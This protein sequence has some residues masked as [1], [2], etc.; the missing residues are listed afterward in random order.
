[1]ALLFLIH[2]PYWQ[3]YR[4]WITVFP[5][6]EHVEA[7]I[8]LVIIGLLFA[9]AVY[10]TFLLVEWFDISHTLDSFED[11][12][13]ALLPILWIFLLY[14]FI[15]HEICEELRSNKENLRITLNSIGDAVIATNI[16]GRIT[17]M[18]PVAENLTGWKSGEVKGKKLEEVLN[19]VDSE[20]RTKIINPVKNVLT[21]GKTV[22]LGNHTILISKEGREYHITDSAAPI[23]AADETILGVVLVFSDITSNFLQEV[24]LRESEERLNLALTGT[25][26]GLYDWN[27][28][29]GKIFINQQWA[30]LIGYSLYELESLTMAVWEKLKHTEDVLRSNEVL[31]MH[32]KGKTGFYECEYRMKHKSGHWIWILDRGM[33][34]RWDNPGNPIRMTGTL[35]DISSLKNTELT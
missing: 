35:I 25:K 22:G 9:T 8:K 33:I 15:Q 4:G 17:S 1:M 26:A 21:T 29:T 19:I 7:D 11:M 24:K 5:K 14:S 16:N 34:V 27:L 10:F 28:Q 3:R 31:E 30:S 6:K 2:R 18:N 32:L 20:T 13:G 23:F 12:T